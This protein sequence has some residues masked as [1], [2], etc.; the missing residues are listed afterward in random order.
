MFLLPSSSSLYVMPASKL[1]KALCCCRKQK[2]VGK[3][4]NRYA[5]VLLRR[6]FGLDRVIS[7]NNSRVCKPVC[8]QIAFPPVA[9]PLPQIPCGILG[10]VHTTPDTAMGGGNDGG[11]VAF[12]DAAAGV[13]DG[14]ASSTAAAVD[15]IPR[16][17][18]DTVDV[19][20]ITPTDKSNQPGAS[21]G[22]KDDLKCS[23]WKLF[24]KAD[25][26]DLLFMAIGTFGACCHGA[27]PKTFHILPPHGER[28]RPHEVPHAR[29][30]RSLLQ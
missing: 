13:A 25:R 1:L 2:G 24:S 19:L 15:V 22:N 26:L 20:R 6:P 11:T 9:A 27:W 29:V 16:S 8:Q 18:S 5:F 7:P 28:R 4:W 17:S 23:Y 21:N 14:K 10:C 3:V 30:C 12:P